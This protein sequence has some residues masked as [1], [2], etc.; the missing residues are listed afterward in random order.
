M[1]YFLSARSTPEEFSIALLRRLESGEKVDVVTARLELKE[2]QLVNDGEPHLRR[3]DKT[4]SG[5]ATPAQERSAAQ[6]TP[7]PLSEAIAILSRELSIQHF[8]RVR[9]IMTSESV[10]ADPEL[11]HNIATAFS[12]ADHARSAE[13]SDERPYCPPMVRHQPV[14]KTPPGL[15]FQ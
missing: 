3:N 8:A 4:D 6:I 2:F 11:A 9:K 14:S 15:H 13:N 12:I 5:A 1:L 10:L 7:G